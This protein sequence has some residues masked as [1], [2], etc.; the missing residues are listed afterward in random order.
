MQQR[1]GGFEA[2][3]IACA[4]KTAEGDSVMFCKYQEAMGVIVAAKLGGKG[5]LLKWLM[6]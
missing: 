2:M 1:A 4:L 5:D 6:S 3:T